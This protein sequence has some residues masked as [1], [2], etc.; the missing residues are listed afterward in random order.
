MEIFDDFWVIVQDVLE[1][2]FL[3]NE[4]VS[5]IIN[6]LEELFIVMQNLFFVIFNVNGYL[7]FEGSDEVFKN[8][9][10]LEE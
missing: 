4:I 1:E 2:E 5:Y 3:N 9:V 7:V 6:V 8:V 10:E